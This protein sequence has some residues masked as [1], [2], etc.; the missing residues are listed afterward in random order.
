MVDNSKDKS[1]HQSAKELFFYDFKILL[2]LAEK[3]GELKNKKITNLQ[4]GI[5]YT[6]QDENRLL[7]YK[8]NYSNS[9][10]NFL[11]KWFPEVLE[12]K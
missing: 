5:P 9:K 7:A 11:L 12:E 3:I 10:R 2:D 1:C 6:T 4:S 8:N